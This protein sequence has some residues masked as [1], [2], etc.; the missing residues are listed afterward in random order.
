MYSIE[1]NNVFIAL[2]AASFGHYGSLPTFRWNVYW[3]F[4][5]VSRRIQFVTSR[6]TV[7]FILAVLVT[8][9]FHRDL[10]CY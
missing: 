1:Q 10:C 2:V 6:N 3:K 9:S 5:Y 7:M 4:R 8:P